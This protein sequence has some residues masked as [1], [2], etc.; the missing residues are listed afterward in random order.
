MNT[1]T[2]YISAGPYQDI[3]SGTQLILSFSDGVVKLSGPL[4]AGRTRLLHELRITLAAEKQ[5]ALLFSPP[6]KTVQE[7]HNLLTRQYSL[8]ADLGFRKSL[9]RYIGN[10]PRD[11]QNLILI[12]DDVEQMDDETLLDLIQFRN[13]LHNGQRVITLI[14]CGLPELNQRMA[15]SDYDEL[16]R[17]IVLNYELEPLNRQE[18]A[19][20]CMA[21]IQQM[22]L[23]IPMP[24]PRALDALLVETGGLPGLVLER[25]PMVV[26]E[27]EMA[28][29]PAPLA[30]LGTNGGT[31]KVGQV[32]DV[33]SQDNEDFD[34]EDDNV[35]PLISNKIR[36][37]LYGGAAIAAGVAAVYLIY[38][39]VA[40]MLQKPAP[41][42]VATISA[43]PAPTVAEPAP[44]P[45]QVT[46]V[47]TPVAE[48]E[49]VAVIPEPTEVLIDTESTMAAPATPELVTTL[50]PEPVVDTVQLVVVE[51]EPAPVDT[52]AVSTTEPVLTPAPAAPVVAIQPV[53]PTPAPVTPAAST[54]VSL[55][56]IFA[57]AAL[58]DDSPAALEALVRNW[59][60]AWQSQNLDAYFGA[61]H[62][63]FAP[64]Y[65]T[66]RAAWQDNRLRSV[67]RPSAISI[68]MD[69]FTINGVSA[70]GT[71]VSFWMEYHTPTYADRT[72]K[73]LVVGHDVDGSL[74]ILQEINRQVSTLVPSQVLPGLNTS[75]IAS[76]STPAVTQPVASAST[77]SNA[78]SGATSTQIGPAIQLSAGITQPTTPV[79]ASAGVT[80]AQTA[81]INAFLGSWLDAWQ[82]Q[83]IV[84]YFG[85]YHPD[86]KSTAHASRV[87]WQE[88]RI[89][90][91][92]TPL[93]IQISLQN[94]QVA[95]ATNTNSAVELQIEYHSTYYAD[96]TVKEIQLVR[97]ASGSW[98]ITQEKNLRIEALPLAR[99]IPG[100]TITLRGG[101]NTIFEYAL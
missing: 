45:A 28:P 58:Q 6:P 42:S 40:P 54:T 39:L 101:I 62:T 37:G 33:S 30:T 70:V 85:H 36:K 66:T 8:G 12:F 43:P 89:R 79:L 99:L 61:Y 97:S 92:I 100:N 96:R 49:A 83:D 81:E 27:P 67:S 18:L 64:M 91:I 59:L 51:A 23:S 65:Q 56:P 78:G 71:H 63:D 24:G 25:L 73:E 44:A 35:F 41:A 95:S 47:I 72:L 7:L 68:A 34:D 60:G 22:E 90:K 50:E 82:Q 46:E 21:A 4:G 86:F 94:L 87:D 9:A 29:E 31:L 80:A 1:A 19:D 10:K 52:P 74:R 13:M 53:I 32:A 3:I 5:E 57:T 15:A 93:A 55:V 75:V 76:T 38:P 14:L 11:Q 2:P 69:E 98:Q 16:T 20:F 17:D 84:A 26:G 48:P 88:D 77:N